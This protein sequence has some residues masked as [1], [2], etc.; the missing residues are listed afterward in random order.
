[1]LRALTDFLEQRGKKRIICERDGQGVYL[2]RYYLLF[3]NSTGDFKRPRWF[4]INIMLHHLCASDPEGLHDHPW[5][6]VSIVIKGGYWEHT[7]NGRFWRSPGS[8]I[9]RTAKTLH[10]LELDRE[11]AGDETW[12]LFFVGPRLRDWGFVSTSGRWLHWQEY[13]NLPRENR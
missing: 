7:P 1:M 11:R 5:W 4:P 8:I 9:F 6:N 12:S 10:R 2:E 3:G 13:L